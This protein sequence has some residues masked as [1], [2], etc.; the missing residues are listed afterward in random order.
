MRIQIRNWFTW[1]KWEKMLVTKAEPIPE[2]LLEIS[3]DLQNL[4]SSGAEIYDEAENFIFEPIL[5]NGPN[6]VK[7]YSASF[8]KKFGPLS[9]YHPVCCNIKESM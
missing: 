3:N 7:N 5:S 2:S 6:G 9:V 8:I 1:D 4:S